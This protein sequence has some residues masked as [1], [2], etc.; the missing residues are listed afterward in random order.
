MLLTSQL[1]LSSLIEF[2]RA[3]RH[4]L[5]AGLSLPDVFRQQSERGPGPVRP[6]AT[7]IY[8]DLANG[9]SLEEALKREKAAFPPMFLSLAEIGRAHV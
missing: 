5:G 8:G 1:P 6:I 2:C 9:D 7:R 3:L 4:N